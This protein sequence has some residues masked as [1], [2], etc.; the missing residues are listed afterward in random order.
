M[1][2]RAVPP[3]GQLVCVGG[4]VGVG[5]G[6]PCASSVP[7]PLGVGVGPPLVGDPEPHAVSKK[8]RQ[9]PINESERWR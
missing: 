4:R 5:V 7:A 1:A 9:Q 8:S 3:A 6:R 2:A